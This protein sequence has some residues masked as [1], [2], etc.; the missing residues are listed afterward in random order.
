[1]T[2]INGVLATVAGLAVSELAAGLT[3]TRVTP[4]LAVGQ[5]VIEY[6]PGSVAERAISAVGQWDK[7]LLVAGVLVVTLVIGAFLGSQA[8]RRSAVATGGF[9]V[10]ALIGAVAVLSRPDG[11]ALSVVAAVA[12]AGTAALALRLLQKQR[13]SS[14]PPVAVATG[15]G[16]PAVDRRTVLRNVVVVLAGSAVVAGAGRWIGHARTAVEQ[17]RAGLRLPVRQIATPDGTDPTV[18]GITP[19]K[20]PTADFYRIDTALSPPLIK[21]EDWSLRIHGMVEQEL[22]LTYQDLVDRGL[23]DAWVTLCCVSNPVGGDLIGNT[24]FSG[25]P[26]KQILAEVGVLPEADALL[27]TSEDGW[28]C[29]TPLEALTDGRNSLLAVAMDGEPLTVDHGFPVRQVVPGLYGYVSATKWV[30]DWEVTR[31]GAFS[32]YWTR[33]G[34]S[35]KGPV[36]THSRIDT[37]GGDVDAGPV[38]VA[39]VAWAQHRGIEAVEVRVDGGAWQPATLSTVDGGSV[40]TNGDADPES[41]RIDTW[42]QW[43]WDWEATGGDHTLEVRATDSTGEPQTSEVADVLPDGATGYHSVRLSVG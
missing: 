14:E 9:A 13:R 28:T 20:T 33:R 31:F 23:V 6:T 16:R 34:W 26:T 3:G 41:T 22:T 2:K 30:V 24:S 17:T 37:P 5:L 10:L 32:A 8:E 11:R 38:K 4:T 43:V 12:G 25:V 39:G 15:A 7:P 21:P 36:K 18:K 42:V 19:W 35:D 29:G 40:S 27:S 1:M